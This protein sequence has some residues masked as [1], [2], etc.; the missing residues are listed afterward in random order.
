MHLLD[1]AI[2]LINAAPDN[3]GAG[4][5]I[6]VLHSSE[7]DAALPVHSSGPTTTE[8]AG[9]LQ[10]TQLLLEYARL[11]HAEV[12]IGPRTPKGCCVERQAYLKLVH[13]NLCCVAAV[14]LP[15]S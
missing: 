11:Q 4:P 10:A 8:A 3:P 6:D 1:A 12:S 15:V 5:A 7:V 9:G 14:K 2:R 13:S